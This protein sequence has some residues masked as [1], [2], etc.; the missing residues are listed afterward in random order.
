MALSI[1]TGRQVRPRRVVVY[2]PPGVGK[3]YFAASAPSPVFV[4]TEEGIDDLEVARFPTP[5]SMDE[6]LGY[7]T[8]LCTEDHQFKTVV[9]DSADW[10]ERIIW[11]DICRDQQVDTIDLACGGFGK[12]YSLACETFGECLKALD[13]LARKKGMT[14]VLIAHARAVRF[15]DPE[16][17]DYDRWEPKLHRQVRDLIVEWASEV[18]FCTYKTFTTKHEAGFGKEVAKAVGGSERVMRC[19]HK[20]TAVAKNRLGM[21]DELPLDWSSY[22]A[23]IVGEKNGSSE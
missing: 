13:F 5:S 9:I 18:L 17:A 16:H 21:P 19:T 23:F 15:A 1:T 4:P 22:Q 11:Q 6:V 3:S 14:S 20:A 8:E 12:G 2:G 7:L 10:L